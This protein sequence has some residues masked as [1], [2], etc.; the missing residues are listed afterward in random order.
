MPIPSPVAAETVERFVPDSLKELAG[1]V[2]QTQGF[3]ELLV[4]LRQGRAGTVDGAWN[5]AAA[6]TAAALA[7]H[8]PK[9][10]VVVLAHP[11]DVDPWVEDLWSFTGIRAHHFPAWDAWPIPES[12]SDEVAGQRLRILK[13]LDGDA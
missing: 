5:S 13:Q 2:Q 8:A 6:L 7:Q 11:R 3:A 1:A 12:V 10:L 4:A 9:T